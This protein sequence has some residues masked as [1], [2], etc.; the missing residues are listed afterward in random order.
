MAAGTIDSLN[1]Q[2]SAQVQQATKNINQLNS[3]LDT[4][5]KKIRIDTSSFNLNRVAE[6][7]KRFSDTV[8]GI[9]EITKIDGTKLNKV[10]D[11]MKSLATAANILNG[12]TFEKPLKGMVNSLAGAK[13]I[14]KTTSYV[15]DSMSRLASARSKAEEASRKTSSLG[16]RVEELKSQLKSLK[17]QGFNFGDAEFDRIY[18]EL[19]KAEQELNNYKNNLKRSGNESKSMS[20]KT[21]DAFSKVRNALRLLKEDVKS[22]LGKLKSVGK[23]ILS[24]SGNMIAKGFKAAGSAISSFTTKLK[25]N[26]PL[27][28]KTSQSTDTLIGKLGRLYVAYYS[29]RR[30]GRIFSGI[31]NSASD[32]IEEFNYF[33]VSISKIAKESQGDYK[34][35]GY[36]SAQEY[37]DSFKGRLTELTRKMSG[38]KIGENGELFTNANIK[39]LGLDVTEITNFESRIAQMTNSVG[40]I[41]EAS[42]AASK[43]LTMLSGDLSSLANVP[44]KQVMNNLS[45]GL[46]GASM[47]VKKYGIDISVATLK[48][49]AMSLGIEKSITKMTQAEKEYL[50][51]ITMINQSKVAWGDLA[52]TINQPA[53]QFRMLKNNL[54]QISLLIGNMFMP[55]IQKVMPYINA[56]AIAVKD[57]IQWISDLFGLKWKNTAQALPDTG[58]FDSSYDDLVSDAEDAADAT[59]KAADAQKKYNKQLQSFDELN[60]LTTTKNKDKDKDDDKDDAD[61]SGVLSDALIRAVEDYEKRWNKAFQSMHNSAADL[62]KTIEDLFKRAWDTGDGTEIGEALATTLNKGIA[63]VNE[64]TD[65][66]SEGLDKIASILGT[67]L[68]GA[69]EKFDFPGLGEAV[70]NSI[71]A[72]LGAEE[73]FFDTVDWTTLGSNLATSLNTAIETGVLQQSFSTMASKIKAA[74]ETAFGAITT[75]KFKSFG[76]AIGEGINDFFA[77]M[78]EVN[79]KT[80]KNGWEELAISFSEGVKGALEAAIATVTTIH[81]EDIGQAIATLISNMDTDGIGWNLGKLANS[82]ATAFYVLVSKRE[83]WKLLGE[84]I[85]GGINGFLDGMNEIDPETKL[86]GWQAL[87][88]SISDTFLG[89]GDMIITALDTIEWEKVGQAIADFITS[90]DW[91]GIIWKL[92]EVVAS[93]AKALKKTL[94]GAGVPEPLAN[95]IVNVGIGRWIIKKLSKTALGAAIIT[96]LGKKFAVALFNV[97]ARIKSWITSGINKTGLKNK[98]VSAVG[99]VTTTLKNVAVTIKGWLVSAATSIADK[100]KT[101]MP[102]KVNTN[103]TVEL[104]ADWKPTGLENAINSAIKGFGSFGISLLVTDIIAGD[105]AWKHFLGDNSNVFSEYEKKNEKYSDED[106][107]KIE[108]IENSSLIKDFI[109]AVGK[110]FNGDK[111]ETNVKVNADTTELD[112]VTASDKDATVRYKADTKELEVAGKMADADHE[113]TTTYKANHKELDKVIKKALESLE[114]VTKFGTDTGSLDDAIAKAKKDHSNTTTFKG[115]EGKSLKD[116]IEKA[117]AT[118]TNDTKFDA[119]PTVAFKN[120]VKT[121]KKINKNKTFTATINFKTVLDEA[122][123]KLGSAAPGNLPWNKNKHAKGSSGLPTDELGVVNDQAGNTYKELIIPPNG[124]PFIPEG[125]N[126][127]L[128]M[129]KGTRVIPAGKTRQFINNLP[130]FANGTEED[131]GTKQDNK[132]GTGGIADGVS[133]AIND[134][135]MPYIREIIRILQGNAS[136]G[137]SAASKKTT[138]KYADT[139]KEIQKAWTGLAKWFETTVTE[140]IT[141]G[142]NTM[143]EELAK[144]FDATNE[145]LTQKYTEASTEWQGVLSGIPG[146][147]SENVGSEITNNF[148]DFCSGIKEGI[149]TAWGGIQDV[150]TP[151]PGWIESN[152]TGLVKDKFT[153]IFGDIQTSHNTMW[154]IMS[155]YAAGKTDWITAIA[156]AAFTRF[157]YL[158]NEFENKLGALERSLDLTEGEIR[159]AEN[160]LNETSNKLSDVKRQIEDAQAAANDLNAASR[161]SNTG[162]LESVNK[163]VA[164]NI[165]TIP[166]ATQQFVQ[167][168]ISRPVENVLKPLLENLKTAGNVRVKRYAAGGFPEDGWFRA[169]HGEIMGQFDNG[170]SVVANNNQITSGIADAVYPAVYN[171]MMAAISSSGGNGGDIVVQIDGENVFRA[172]R[173]KDQDFYKRTHKSAFEH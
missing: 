82:L 133:Q 86:N 158:I 16:N 162:A 83:T 68:N 129:Q 127:V 114:N 46:A 59:D 70:G 77:K 48:E 96:K 147:I 166:D 14:S 18:S 136:S 151:V 140:P 89:F 159:Q 172:V 49:Q 108:E 93:F 157:S 142:F 155:K 36:D 55:M 131:A 56:M 150:L 60:N 13:D 21:A 91:G 120:A 4:L 112:K 54:K 104:G 33:N 119:D 164:K 132:K 144:V 10:A 31:V 92:G 171:A 80:G 32:Y 50:R 163:Y 154:D 57:L 12:V 43:G 3:T 71:K 6:T 73:K 72:A 87:G 139:V 105:D 9:S 103:R 52:T 169:S 40:M 61:V 90:I 81:W 126:V 170:Q 134:T 107:K 22:L 110:L 79:K 15:S 146:W 38:F 109:N 85:A 118:H 51:V 11:G 27:I 44:L 111:K 78:N 153:G 25:Q 122:T 1:I 113:N 47:A 30:I 19:Q 168:N 8:K 7:T 75:F 102:S 23:A 99:K 145:E 34:K 117:E 74:I 35:Y 100:I 39:N 67:S 130:H 26:I 101:M 37:A 121:W 76:T 173:N 88:K 138:T 116:A 94:K 65:K 167:N 24:F 123:K 137:G 98:I 53:N 69:I 115:K 62:A 41:G 29:L 165:A 28:N 156:E 42:I 20:E 5:Q 141:K 106:L 160:M 95:L 2:I 124:K 63:W 45:S 17:S 143:K 125:R 149:E 58:E 66:F 148:T 84:K 161:P 135:L 128:P 152:V 97:G 64:H